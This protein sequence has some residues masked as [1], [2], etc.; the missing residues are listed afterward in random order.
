MKVNKET[1]LLCLN[2]MLKVEQSVSVSP[3]GRNDK[4]ML[5]LASGGQAHEN[6]E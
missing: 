4:L 2:H 5:H 6:S 3:E 1:I